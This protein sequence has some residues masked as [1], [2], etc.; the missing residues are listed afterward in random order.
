MLN[1]FYGGQ[2]G[3]NFEIKH[4]FE[5][6]V[7]LEK[8][9][10]MAWQS[11]IAVG[12]LVFISYGLPSGIYLKE[13]MQIPPAYINE[14][15]QPVSEKNYNTRKE[16]DINAYGLSYNSTLW[17]KIYVE[18]EDHPEINQ[19]TAAIGDGLETIYSKEQYGLA[20]K[21]I[22]SLTGETPLVRF[23][24]VQTLNCNQSPY[25]VVNNND[26]D[27]PKIT[28]YLPQAQRIGGA[29]TTILDPVNLP[30]VSIND[31]T[32]INNP[33]LNFSLPRAAYFWFSNLFNGNENYNSLIELKIADYPTLNNIFSSARIGDYYIERSTGYIYYINS[34][35]RNA[36]V[37]NKVILSFRA[38]LSG[39]APDVNINLIDS[40]KKE[41]EEFVINTPYSETIYENNNF[42]TNP[43]Y[44]FSLPQNPKLE[45]TYKIGPIINNNT[46]QKVET[47]IIDE[48]TINFNFTIP[49]GPLNIVSSYELSSMDE[50]VVPNTIAAVGEFLKTTY[51]RYLEP[52]ELIAVNYTDVSEMGEITT[53]YL[54]YCYGQEYDSENNIIAAIWNRST[55]TGGIANIIESEKV[56]NE[57]EAQQKVYN[58]AYINL[59]ENRIA[60]LEELL[61][62]GNIK[63]LEN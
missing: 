6:K 36:D 34:L 20:Y 4:I 33:I 47:K 3:K 23:A 57:I 39:L 28:L 46:P 48:N 44:T 38:N 58:A 21:L 27:M 31:E 55:L 17:Q 40:Y 50:V 42:Y 35:E 11:P 13:S 45:A 15:L 41:N 32:D 25:I 24:D 59:L 61:T 8:D 63:N 52:N 26:S 54:Y 22:C 49:Q 62:W 37:I 60:A 43:Q 30:F 1:S 18:L 14:E 16:I 12:D 5:T 53:S 2:Q 29:E 7:D 10:N 9:L 56:E 19:A 51:G